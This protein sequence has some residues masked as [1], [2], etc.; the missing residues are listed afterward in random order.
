MQRKHEEAEPE[1]GFATA[2]AF[3]T[4]LKKHHARSGGLRLRLAK[5]G[6]E[7]SVSYAQ[8]VE[9]ALA[10]GWIDGHKQSLGRTHW[11][12]RFTPRAAKSPWSKLN[13]QKAE[14]LIA[15]KKMKAPG[16]AEVERA[17]ADGR[18]ER[19][20]D[21]PKT[22]SVPDDLAQA[23]AKN[24]RADAFFATLDRANRY[25]ILYRVHDAKKAETRA[26]RIAQFVALCARG[27]VL[28]PERAK[29][30]KKKK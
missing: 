30:P 22:S 27:E 3:E 26:A 11:I 20:Y 1:L 7:P 8:A 29:R 9:V 24:K 16:L 13:C 10:W 19:A 28:H 17:K 4:W 25:A 5:K 6:G 2:A 23:L 15:A 12:Q 18:W 21:S 14:A